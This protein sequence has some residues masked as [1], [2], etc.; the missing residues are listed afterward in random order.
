V[1][2]S[3]VGQALVGA[4][5]GS[6]GACEHV[7]EIRACGAG[8]VFVAVGE[9]LDIAQAR[10]GGTRVWYPWEGMYST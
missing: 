6:G 3:G 2:V 4:G 5:H 10:N 1:V 9:Y 8:G 7:S